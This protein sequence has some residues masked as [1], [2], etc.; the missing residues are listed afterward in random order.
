MVARG[1]T[2]RFLGVPS[3][4]RYLRTRINHLEALL[5]FEIYMYSHMHIETLVMKAFLERVS[6]RYDILGP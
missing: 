3:P 2:W 4:S 5:Y 6:V 1:R